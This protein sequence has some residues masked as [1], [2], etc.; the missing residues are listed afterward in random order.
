MHLWKRVIAGQRF[1]FS[2]DEK[3]YQR[4]FA[5]YCYDPGPYD[6]P[7]I[8]N[9]DTRIWARNTVGWRF[10][11][12]LNGHLWIGNDLTEYWSGRPIDALV[13]RFDGLPLS[14]L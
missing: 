14:R 10:S 13:E 2:A 12:G 1:E 4:I 9:S 8:L 5:P 3:P 7:R 11:G 6:D